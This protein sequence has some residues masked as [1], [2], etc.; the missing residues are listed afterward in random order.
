MPPGSD[1]LAARLE[2]DEGLRFEQHGVLDTALMHYER[3]AR[4]SNE[5]ALISEAFRRQS[6]VHRTRCDWKLAIASAERAI[7]AAREARL[8]DLHSE[9]LSAFAAVH[10]SR[11]D[12][13]DAEAML[14]SALRLAHD[15]RVRGIVLQ[16]L[17]GI[18]AE[19]HDLDTAE[20]KFVESYAC[21]R[22]SGY[23][24]GEAFA[25]NNYGRALLE[26]G[27]G[28]HAARVLGQAIAIARDVGD[29]ELVALAT[30]NVAETL[31][32]CGDLTTAESQVSVALGYFNHTQNAWRQIEC[33]RLLGDITAKAQELATAVQCYVRGMQLALRI[34][35]R[36]EL[37]V[38]ADC[39]TR[40]KPMLGSA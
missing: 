19:K 2:L 27:N 16:N 17:G 14:E 35:A 34:G 24:R 33:L 6:S 32:L 36:Q 18:A 8:D 38:L 11:G 37:A 9:A 10:R 25:L 7:S 21:F 3:A 22:R 4:A 28:A 39:L 23:R 5:A 31:Y 12:F 20:H 29:D 30:L 15:E 26:G 13:D 1:P 40:V